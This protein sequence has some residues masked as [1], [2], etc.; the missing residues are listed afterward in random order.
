VLKLKRKGHPLF[1]P[2]KTRKRNFPPTEKE[3][4]F[5]RDPVSPKSFQRKK[6]PPPPSLRKREE[7]IFP[8]VLDGK[9][10]GVRDF[11]S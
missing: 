8:R 4:A 7:K 3:K 10:V 11:P 6:K 9:K 1:P 2:G 5:R